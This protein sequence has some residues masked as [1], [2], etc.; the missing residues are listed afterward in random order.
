MSRADDDDVLHLADPDDRADEW[1]EDECFDAVPDVGTSAQ[2]AQVGV[3]DAEGTYRPRRARRSSHGRFIAIVGVVVAASSIAAVFA[4]HQ[5]SSPV[6]EVVSAPSLGASPIVNSSSVRPTVSVSVKPT[7]SESVKPSTSGKPS[8]SGKPSASSKPSASASRSSQASGSGKSPGEQE[9]VRRIDPT[10]VASMSKATG[11]PDRALTAYA[12]AQ[13]IMQ[14]MAPSCGVGWS[15]LAAIG[16]IESDHGRE[17]GARLQSDGTIDRPILGPELNGVG[18]G[19]VRDTDGGRLDG[20]STWD[21]AVGPMQLLP[22]SWMTFGVDANGDGIADPNN[23]D[24][25]TVAAGRLLCSAGPLTTSDGWRQAVLTYNHSDD[26]V[27]A[28]ATKSNEYVQLSL[29]A[30]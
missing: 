6:R 19:A 12:N 4:M 3:D 7:Q 5:P 18:V 28:V 29:K 22:S 21:R 17:N 20:D 8:V 23:I 30:R 9:V 25:A 27:N 13:L 24:D 1:D 11:I 16:F 10:W 15:T 26:Y 2:R 14:Q